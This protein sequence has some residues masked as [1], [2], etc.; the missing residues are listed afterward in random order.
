M[1][2]AHR[3]A[4][5][6]PYRLHLGYEFGTDPK[7][8]WPAQFERNKRGLTPSAP[9]A[10]KIY[11]PNQN[12]PSQPEITNPRAPLTERW[13]KKSD[14]Y[15]TVTPANRVTAD[16]EAD[17]S[18]YHTIA[19]AVAYAKS[20]HT[21]LALIYTDPIIEIEVH[22]GLYDE[23]VT[24]DVNY[25][26]FRGIGMPIITMTTVPVDAETSVITITADCTRTLVDGFEIINLGGDEGD[27]FTRGLGIDVLE[28]IESGTNISDVRIINC[29]VHG[30]QTQA[31]FQR[32]IY[33]ENTK[34]YSE[35]N[36]SDPVVGFP[37]H[38]VI[39]R[40][41]YGNG[42]TTAQKKWSRFVRCDISGESDP[43]DPTRRGGAIAI[44]ALQSNFTTWVAN[45]VTVG[46]YTVYDPAPTG[47]VFAAGFA[48]SGV[49]LQWCQITGSAVNYGW[50]IEYFCCQIIQG[51]YI[52]G[53]IGG[54]HLRMICQTTGIVGQPASDILSF[55][56]FKGGNAKVTYLVEYLDHNDDSPTATNEVWIKH[57][58]HSAP[59][60][61]AGGSAVI[62]IGTALA[63]VYVSESGTS[64]QFW[65]NAGAATQN[66]ASNSNL[67]HMLNTEGYMNL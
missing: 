55:A 33:C 12:R 65:L 45:S 34:F 48:I 66:N 11:Y 10:E 40:F 25:L 21:A 2:P 56:W 27:F 43:A 57:F 8:S 63:H 37:N 14:W 7:G 4:L 28:G 20:I 51:R 62:A 13:H 16:P 18:A 36:L 64:M 26:R 41:G 1:L 50:A 32:W 15:I 38:S 31:Y 67:V 39:C 49:I 5:K 46:V 42:T 60:L 24:I 59:K 35:D 58:E 3:K 47:A 29:W 22:G 44:F 53:L 54:V 30:N 6:R 52:S 61:A 9:E 23:Q 17:P 19:D